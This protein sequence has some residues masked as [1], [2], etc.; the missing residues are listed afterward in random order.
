MASGMA[1]SADGTGWE[2]VSLVESFG[3]AGAIEIA[4]L[5]DEF[6]IVFGSGQPEDEQTIS[7]PAWRI[8]T[9][10]S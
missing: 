5:G 1:A 7:D 8:A 9:P 4:A 2:T 10:S 3:E 6:I